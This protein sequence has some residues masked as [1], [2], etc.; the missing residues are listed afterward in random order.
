MSERIEAVYTAI[1][2]TD[3]IDNI[4]TELER[5]IPLVDQGVKVLTLDNN[6]CQKESFD[7]YTR[8]TLNLLNKTGL[9][10]KITII[11]AIK[12]MMKRLGFENI[13]V[14]IKVHGLRTLVS[15]VPNKIDIFEITTE[16]SSSQY[17][18]FADSFHY[19]KYEPFLPNFLLF[20]TK[21]IT[22]DF[23]EYLCQIIIDN[24]KGHSFDL[25]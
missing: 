13:E 11:K 12:K 19:E 15:R 8:V 20:I 5:K 3:N 6:H 2:K 16:I 1:I 17:N 7:G 25:Q 21:D 22:L 23:Y 9:N 14:L 24:Y 10:I 18:K 4:L